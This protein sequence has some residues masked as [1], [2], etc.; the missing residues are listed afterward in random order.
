IGLVVPL[1]QNSIQ[2]CP[3]HGRIICCTQKSLSQGSRAPSAGIARRSRCSHLHD[4][5]NRGYIVTMGQSRLNPYRVEPWKEDL[6]RSAP[7]RERN[8]DVCDMRDA[9]SVES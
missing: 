9:N 1:L 5:S 2:I 6:V 4:S 8:E 3:Q 7:E